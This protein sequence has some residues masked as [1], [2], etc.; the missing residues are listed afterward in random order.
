MLT[1]FIRT[2]IL[3]VAVIAAVRLMGKRQIAQLQPTELV[4]TILLSQIAATPMQ[5][6][7]IPMLNTL[8]AVMVLVG[9]EILISYIGM[10]NS[11]FRAVLQGNP[12]TVIK[13]G[14]L[15]QKQLAR[16]RYTVDDLMESLRAKDVFDISSVSCAVAETDGSLSVLLRPDEQPAAAKQ[17]GNVPTDGDY[18]YIII[19]DGKINRADFAS[20][21]LTDAKF[22]R[23][24]DGLE[25][26]P[27]DVFLMTVKKSGGI[28]LI[29][30]DGADAKKRV[31]N[32]YQKR[33]HGCKKRGKNG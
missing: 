27:K 13:E 29:R 3:L 8:V 6:N 30:K 5:D 11:R 14:R 23:I 12:V 33:R 2:L 18:P 15:D 7:D 32:S 10:K 17:V 16:I 24:T 4:V 22:R 31:N 20:A 25:V 21:G 9:V 19:S 26:E 1:S 28:T